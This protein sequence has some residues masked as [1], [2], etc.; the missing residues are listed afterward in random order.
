M[1]EDESND[2]EMDFSEVLDELNEIATTKHLKIFVF[3]NNSDSHIDITCTVNDDN[4]N[5][6][7]TAY[8]A[9]TET[10]MTLPI[11]LYATSF[12][13][14]VY[15]NEIALYLIQTWIPKL[16]AMSLEVIH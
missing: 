1:D 8:M 16:M 9:P 7:H 3:G 13:S 15:C 14:S 4:D 2:S 5:N 6:T 11:E 12:T 10:D